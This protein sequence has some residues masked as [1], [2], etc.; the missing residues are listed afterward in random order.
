MYPHGHIGYHLKPHRLNRKGWSQA[1]EVTF[2][3][4][5]LSFLRLKT[6][7]YVLRIMTINSKR[8][9]NP[10]PDKEF[11]FTGKGKLFL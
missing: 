4:K 7:F 11:S 2:L 10:D 5:K 8:Y 9:I 3:N 6:N 1:K